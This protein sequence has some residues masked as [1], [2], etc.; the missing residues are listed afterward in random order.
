MCDGATFKGAAK[1]GAVKCELAGV[2]NSAK[3]EDKEEDGDRHVSFEKVVDFRFASF[4]V[5]LECTGATF[6]ERATF[7]AIKCGDHAQL[8]SATFESEEQ[9]VDFHRASI[10]GALICTNTTFNGPV[11]FYNATLG[12]LMLGHNFQFA[13]ET[14]NLREFTFKRFDGTPEQAKQLVEAQNPALFSR[15]PYIQL[16]QYY[17]SVGK[18]AQAKDIYYQ[19]HQ[20]ARANAKKRN[21]SVEWSRGTNVLDWL[22]K[23]L[24]RYGISIWRLLAIAIAFVSLGTLIFYLPDLYLSQETLKLASDSAR[25]APWEHGW[26]YRAAYSLDLFLPQVNLHIDEKWIPSTP[27]LQAYAIIHSMIGWLIVPLLIA[28]LAGIMRR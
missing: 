8:S 17:S 6:K 18:D 28:A 4:G 10:G 14:L 3:P 23:A 9:L 15:D 26:L 5:N 13:P 21:G 12:I 7:A 25:T 20:A 16:E 27:L 24:T 22:W 2:F 1:F 11:D 19:G